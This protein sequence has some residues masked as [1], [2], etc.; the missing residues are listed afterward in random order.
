MRF[1]YKVFLASIASVLF[2]YVLFMTCID[3][4][5]FNRHF[6][7]RQYE[8]LHTAE[9]I[10]MSDTSLYVATDTL[11]DYLKEYRDDM[12]VQVE[13]HGKRREVFDTREKTHMIDVKNLYQDAMFV[14][15]VCM[16]IILALFVLL[17]YD[18]KKE[19]KEV[20]SKAFIKV[21]ILFLFLLCTLVLYALS[22]FN[23]FWTMFHKLFFTNDLWLLDPSISLMINMF[24]ETFFYHLVMRIAV[25]FI[26]GLLILFVL[27]VRYQRK[28]RRNFSSIGKK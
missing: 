1:S 2:I 19:I 14:R 13:V 5:A 21:C 3:M 8:R 4:H 20:L 11:L 27:S 28:L 16:G 26:G 6:Y 18:D 15:N 9:K 10:G 25:S 12:D 7:N 22:D 23:A 24:P 17:Y